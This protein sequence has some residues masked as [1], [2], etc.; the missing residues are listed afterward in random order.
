M[1]SEGAVCQL[2]ISLMI[3]SSIDS[4]DG[5]KEVAQSSLSE[6]LHSTKWPSRYQSALN[7]HCNVSLDTVHRF[8]LIC[9]NFIL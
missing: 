6:Y 7:L 3:G 5:I 2:H 4:G 8:M 1:L 9:C